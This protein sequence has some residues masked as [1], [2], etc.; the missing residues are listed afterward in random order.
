VRTFFISP[1]F[2]GFCGCFECI[3][4]ISLCDREKRLLTRKTCSSILHSVETV[5]EKRIQTQALRERVGCF[6]VASSRRPTSVIELCLAVVVSHSETLRLE[7]MTMTIVA[8]W[9][10]FGAIVLL[11]AAGAAKLGG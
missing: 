2:A 7:D 6:D 1:C 10:G 5:V 3:G 4:K 11:T 9:W 8:L